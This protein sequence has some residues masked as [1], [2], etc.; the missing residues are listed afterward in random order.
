MLPAPEGDDPRLRLLALTGALVTHDPP[1][2]VGPVGSGRGRR[3]LIAF[4][5]RH[6][7]L[8][9]PPEPDGS[10]AEVEAM[11]RLDDL[12]W[13]EAARRA[14]SGADPPQ[15]RWARPSSTGPTSP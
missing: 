7:Y 13:P 8:D 6:G 11:N 5:V 4:L 10:G 2:V 1:T 3:P 12:A 14:E 15:S 9:G